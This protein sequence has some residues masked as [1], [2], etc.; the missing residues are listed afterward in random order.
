MFGRGGPID[1]GLFCPVGPDDV[2][3]GAGLGQA[4]SLDDVAVEPL[5]DRL[6]ELG[7][8]RRRAG[9]DGLHRGEVAALDRR[10]LGQGKGDRG[11]HV[12]ARDA[13][14]LHEAEEL[15]RSKR[16]MVTIV[17]PERRPWFMITVIP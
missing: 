9:H 16:G 4:V 5:G 2:G 13:V 10:M 1:P 3:N 17:A 14:L 15:S 11:D 8:E 12:G 7:A 6:G